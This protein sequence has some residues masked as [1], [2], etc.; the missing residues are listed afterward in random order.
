MRVFYVCRAFTGLETSLLS[1]RWAP[2]GVPTIYKMIEALDAA[3]DVRLSLVVTCRGTLDDTPFA[4]RFHRRLALDG[5]RTPMHVLGGEASWPRFLGRLR[6]RLTAVIHGAWV[7]AAIL[8]QRPALVYVDRANMVIG[9]LVAR[10]TR[11]PVLLRLMGIY[12]EMWDIVNGRHPELR[13]MRWALRAPFAHVICTQDGTP[14]QRFMDAALREGTPRTMMLN[15]VP[16]DVPAMAEGEDTFADIPEGRFVVL[17]IGRLVDIKG[18]LEFLDAVLMLP[19]EDSRLVHAVVVG[20]GPLERAMRQRVADAG[21]EA[22]VSFIPRLRHSQISAA[23]RKADLY[24]SMNRLGNLSNAN[25][26][27][28]RAGMCM[29]VPPSRP[30]EGTDDDLDRL[31]PEDTL[32]RLPGSEPPAAA[33]ARTIIEL[34][35]DPA[36][37]AARGERTR[38]AAAEAIR[39]WPERAEAEL[40]LLRE[41]TGHPGCHTAR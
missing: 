28:M 27:C 5:L 23:H 9:G 12:P 38:R 41:L 31:M 18:P 21:A 3:E 24:V 30:E 40:A 35:H 2:T 19:P 17:F 29:V 6:S 1:G 13:L 15:G 26:E 37:V 39:P 34:A 14:G 22:R 32:I 25:L 20:T 7:I 4:R 33:L 11:I 16:D 36:A 10:F 8:A